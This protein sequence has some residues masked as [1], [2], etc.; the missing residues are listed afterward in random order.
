MFGSKVAA[1]RWQPD[2][3]YYEAYDKALIYAKDEGEFSVLPWNNKLQPPT[4]KNVQNVTLNFGPQHPAAHGVLRLVLE[5]EGEVSSVLE[6]ASES[7]LRLRQV[8]HSLHK[9][10]L[11]LLTYL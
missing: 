5:L 9:L 3:K 7:L 2:A 4:E 11:I 1:A 10:D 6:Q 8:S